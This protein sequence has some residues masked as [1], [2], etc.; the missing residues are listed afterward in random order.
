VIS[1][2][3]YIERAVELVVWPN[4]K[5]VFFQVLT[6]LFLMYQYI[7]EIFEQRTPFRLTSFLSDLG[8]SLEKSKNTI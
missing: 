6:L 3:V 4:N 2:F 7:F 1:G 5:F 8:W